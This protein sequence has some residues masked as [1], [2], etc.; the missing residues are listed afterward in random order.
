MDSASNSKR[1][2]EVESELR[3]RMAIKGQSNFAREAGWAES[4]VSRLNVRDMAVTFVLLEKIWE[5]S[6]IREIAR[7]AVIAV[8]GKQKAPTRTKTSEQQISISF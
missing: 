7:Q 8:T 5:T 2:M 1:I 3:S 4:K 6:V